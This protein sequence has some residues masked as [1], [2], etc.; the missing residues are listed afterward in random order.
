MAKLPNM[1]TPGANYT[2]DTKNYAWH[3]PPD[4]VDYDEGV[5]YMLGRI[6]EPVQQELIFSLLEIDAH[7]TTVVATLL[8]QAISRGKMAIDLAILIAGPI[9][10]YISIIA[11]DS[12]IKHEMGVD[13]KDRVRIT[14]TSLRLSL[15]IIDGDNEDAT[16]KPVGAPT[17]PLDGLMGIGGQTNTIAAS[18][19]VQSAMLGDITDEE[20]TT[21]GLA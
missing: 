21:D 3:R 1:P 19:D 2:S 8:L 18:D 15:N 16:E 9:A 17:E 14:P 20:E 10:R 5:D 11:T 6:K 12:G 4:I 13:D 7:V